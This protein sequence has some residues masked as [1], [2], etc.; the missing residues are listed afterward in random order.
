MEPVADWEGETLLE[1]FMRNSID[2][3]KP[4]ATTGFLECKKM[5]EVMV[6]QGDEYLD[7]IFKKL[8]VEGFSSAPVVKGR[9][10]I[11]HIT[12]LDLVRHVNGLFFGTSQED[13]IDWWDKQLGFQLTP[14]SDIMPITEN[15]G[16]NP[17]PTMSR[18]YT[19]FSALEL[20]ARNRCH[21]ILQMDDQKQLCGILTQ[22][23]LISFLR[24]CKA[25]WSKEFRNLRV[26]N[27]TGMDCPELMTI[28]ENELAINAFLK[29]DQSDILGLP[30]VDDLGVL[31]G[32]ISVRDLKGCGTDGSK[33]SRLYQK[34]KTFKTMTRKENTKLAPATHYSKK[35]VPAGAVYVVPQD[36]IED[37]VRKMDDGNM[38]RVF[39]CDADSS[40]RGAPRPI[41]VISQSDV[42]MQALN[43]TIAES[44]QKPRGKTAGVRTAAVRQS[45]RKVSSGREGA[46]TGRRSIPIQ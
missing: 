27:F 14:A 20:M 33:F 31:K 32:C 30:I 12:L 16:T 24:Q 18:D 35:A 21:Q 41:G 23:M 37:V 43:A 10:L 36:T 3:H 4:R 9:E 5:G 25:K 46:T 44:S 38:H 13:W 28:N 29:M 40:A 11:G 42:L 1:C 8:S 17:F 6:V 15:Y 34:V 45:P 26:E 39:I 19:S 2:D 22:S 7:S